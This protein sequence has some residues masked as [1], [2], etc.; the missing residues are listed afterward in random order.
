[1]VSISCLSI[2]HS[3]GITSA[4]TSDPLIIFQIANPLSVYQSEHL[5]ISVSITNNYFQEILN[6]TV[7]GKTPS[8]LEFLSST[9]HDFGGGNITDEFEHDFGKIS[10]NENINFTV[11]Y[12]VTS[13]DPKTISLTRVN[14]TYTLLNGIE[15]FQLSNPSTAIEI[16]LKGKRETT[17]T[18]TRSPIPTGS[19]PAHASLSV[20]GYVIPLLAYAIS[21][22]ILRRLRH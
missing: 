14:V 1:M 22:I 13:P 2:T 3:R 4:N 18:D 8:E 16:L 17:R 5:D 7:K 12:N 20:L 15:T 19:I 10:V 9:I 6:V 11:T 21:I